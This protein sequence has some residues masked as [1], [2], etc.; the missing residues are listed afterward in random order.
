MIIRELSLENFRNYRKQTIAFDESTNVVYGDNA[1]GKTNLLEA[2]VLLSAGRSPRTRSDRETIAFDADCAR[3]EALTETRA[4][5]FRTEMEL[6]RGRQKKMTVNGVR[7]KRNGDLGGA[8]NTVFF[9]PD[10]LALIRAGAAERRRFL[11]LSLCQL[12]PRYAKACAEYSRALDSKLRILRGAE[13]RPDL[14]DALPEFNAQLAASGAAIIRYRAQYC[15][16]LAVCASAA[17][18]ECSG[19]REELAL[20]YRT[21]S[22]VADP[23]APEEELAERLRAHLTERRAAET[24]SGLCLCGPHKDDIE[25]FIGGRSARTFSSQGQTRTAAL[26]LKLAEREIFKNATGEYPVLLLDDVLSELDDTRQEYVLNRISGG[27]VFITC[28]EDDRL[29]GLVKGK[30]FHVRNGEVS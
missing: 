23:L 3:I 17:H 19:G 11:D 1:Q 8:L 14:L 30:V 10:D 12:R 22:A 4:R 28:C 7:I 2:M 20:A 16:K 29:N 6:C 21:D 9:C 18:G 5:E 24:A 15:E 13:E 26:A 27:Q 25:V